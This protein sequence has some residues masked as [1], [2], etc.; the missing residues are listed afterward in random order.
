MT[1]KCWSQNCPGS[2]HITFTPQPLAQSL[3]QGLQIVTLHLSGQMW[4]NGWRE[5]ENLLDMIPQRN[6][7]NRRWIYFY[8]LSI[9]YL[10][11]V[12]YDY[13]SSITINLPITNWSVYWDWLIF[14]TW[15]TQMGRLEV[16][17]RVDASVFPLKFAGWTL[18]Q[19][20]YVEVLKQECCFFGSPES[21]FKKAFNRL[22]YLYYG[23]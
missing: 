6:R 13:L 23:W 18:R 1:L 10:S 14:R 11:S 21:L 16:Q 5:E 20:F 3:L 4:W 22:N 12:F 9:I 17:G 8:H 15:F 7:T 19:G 2:Q